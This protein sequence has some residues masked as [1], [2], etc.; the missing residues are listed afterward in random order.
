MTALTIPPKRERS[1]TWSRRDILSMAGMLGISLAAPTWAKPPAPP[2]LKQSD[3]AL[4]GEIADIIIPAT[5]TAG[6]KTA[7]V[8]EFARMMVNDWFIE[9]ERQRFQTGLRAFERE[10]KRLH[11]SDFLNLSA[12]QREALVSSSLAAAEASTVGPNA[13]PPFIVLM[14]RLTVL[15]YYTSEVG[16]AEELELNLAPGKYEPCAEAGPAARAGSTGFSNPKFSA[17]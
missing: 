14:K 5:E 8:A 4:I 3:V 1:A 12:R 6:A 16:A 9:E 2:S 10:A 11:G 17:S 13:K 7:R 15:G